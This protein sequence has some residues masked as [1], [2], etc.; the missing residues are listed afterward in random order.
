[1]RRMSEDAVDQQ[2]SFTDGVRID[3]ER[4][5]VLVLPD[6]HRSVVHI[7]VE[8]IDNADADALRDQYHAKVSGWLAELS[9]G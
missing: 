7:Y 4:G 2:A 1:M 3:T 5:W 6:Q 9:A 8:A